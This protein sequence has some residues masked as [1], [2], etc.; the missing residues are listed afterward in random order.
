[1]SAP[2]YLSRLTVSSRA[3]IPSSPSKQ[4]S[5]ATPLHLIGRPANVPPGIAA[6][7]GEVDQDGGL[8]R[9]PLARQKADAAFRQQ[10]LDQHCGAVQC[11]RRGA[12]AI[13]PRGRSKAGQMLNFH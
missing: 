5:S 9:S 3:G 2:P 10:F 1:M 7:S 6:D 8:A 12:S 4:N 11:C 13:S